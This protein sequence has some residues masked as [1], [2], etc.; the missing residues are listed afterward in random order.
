[1]LG[2]LRDGFN[3]IGID[4]YTFDLI[5]GAAILIAMISNVYLAGLRRAGRT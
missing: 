4:A 5:I 2:V 3:L 1:V